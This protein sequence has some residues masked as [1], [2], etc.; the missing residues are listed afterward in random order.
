MTNGYA[1]EINDINSTLKYGEVRYVYT[2]ES[3]PSYR[4]RRFV[5][6]KLM[7]IMATI[8]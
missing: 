5:V 7:P 4:G 1:E 8:I 6:G 3:E 2:A